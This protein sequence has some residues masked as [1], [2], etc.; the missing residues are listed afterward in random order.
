MSFGSSKSKSSSSSVSE[1]WSPT[2][3]PVKGFINKAVKV[4]GLD[5]TPDQMAAF[6]QLKRN[7]G[8]GNP[9]TPQIGALAERTLGYDN[10]AN[11]AMVSDAYRGLQDNLGKYASGGYLDVMSN[12]ELRA[13]MDTVAQDAEERINRS[14]QGMGRARSATNQEALGRGITEAQLPLL[15][16]QFNRQ[17]QNQIAAAQALYGAGGD[18]ASQ[19]SNLDKFGLDYA[20]SGIGLGEQALEARDYAPN[21]IL[22]LDQQI[23]QLP[24][25]NLALLGSLLLPAAGLGGTNNTTGSSK[26]S[27]FGISLSDERAKENIE[28]VGKLADG[29]TVYAYNYKGDPTET[30]HLGL[31]A[32]EVEKVKPEAV[33]EFSNGL[34]GV[35]Y[36]MATERAAQI[37]SRQLAR[38]RNGG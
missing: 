27:G 18:T 17:Q 35:D 23:Q 38:K 16:D 20:A 21:R 15:L 4:G 30:T 32:Q 33:S 8:E 29:Q 3:D 14:F 28:E 19:L 37:V 31:M 36:G 12:P 5:I 7:A 2:I 9:F 13:M 22:N 34:K 26:S 10:T 1:P 11:K 24:Y 25:E 6:G